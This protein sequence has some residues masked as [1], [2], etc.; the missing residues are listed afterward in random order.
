MKITYVII[1]DEERSRNV[2]KKMVEK[3][4]PQMIL[5]GVSDGVDSGV[6]L[7]KKVNPSLVFMDIQLKDGSGFDILMELGKISAKIIF[8]TAYDSYAIKAF[9]FS[10]L[11][12]LLKPIEINELINSINRLEEYSLNN[13]HYRIDSLIQ[14]MNTG[15]ESPPILTISTLKSIDFVKVNE[16]L[17]C[18][19]EGAYCKLILKDGK[20]HLISKVIKEFE[21]L[22]KDHGFFRVHQSHLVNISEINKFIKSESVIVM[23]DNTHI[24]VSKSRKDAFLKYMSNLS[25]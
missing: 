11:D 21:F 20:T 1:E 22:L 7:I 15:F 19:A 14:N 17:R 12:Y 5:L 9:K 3:H 16:I 23:N 10:A 6:K 24:G 13:Q 4:F 18:Q 2:L 8:T 25:V